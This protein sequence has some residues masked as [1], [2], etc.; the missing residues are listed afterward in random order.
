MRCLL[1]TSIAVGIL[2]AVAAT[3]ATAAASTRKHRHA[4]VTRV[5]FAPARPAVRLDAPCPA[6]DAN[7]DAI[8][9]TTFAGAVMC[10]VNQ[11]RAH[12]GLGA[13]VARPLLGEVGLRHAYAMVSEDFFGH[14]EPGGL[15]YRRRIFH[16]G[17]FR[18]PAVGFIAG[19]NIAWTAGDMATPGTIVDGWMNS[20]SHRAEI[21][22]RRFR[23]AGVGVVMGSPP[24]LTEHHVAGATAAMEFGALTYASA[25]LARNLRG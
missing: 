12:Y 17:Y 5:Y 9:A 1:R 6:A 14:V 15:S 7:A 3:P 25:R 18:R 22:D 20:P 24:S 8:N 13:L 10:L 23:E 2:L 11:E 21:L 4:R 16:A 19:E